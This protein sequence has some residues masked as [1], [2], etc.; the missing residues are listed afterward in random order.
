MHLVNK[1]RTVKKR[2]IAE[3][4][5]VI[6]TYYILQKSITIFGFHLYW[7]TYCDGYSESEIRFTL[8]E[9]TH[10]FLFKR[11]SH[12]EILEKSEF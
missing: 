8:P 9:D 3:G 12:T 1:H 6:D 4:G 2:S 5:N 7:K 10:E 11:Y